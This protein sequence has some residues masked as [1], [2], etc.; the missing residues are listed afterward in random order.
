MSF[1]V[2]ILQSEADNSL[3][4]GQTANVDE[5]LKRHNQGRATYT[6]VKKPWKLLYSESFESRA[7]A[8]R[9]EAELK[10][11]HRKDILLELIKLK[12]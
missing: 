7:S 9:R 4:I 11:L 8:V 12:G 10:S 1:Y 2:Y 3:Y 6:K 5:R